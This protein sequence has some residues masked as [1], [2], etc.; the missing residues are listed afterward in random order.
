MFGEVNKC[1]TFVSTKRNNKTKNTHT[2]KTQAE[3][4]QRGQMLKINGKIY[5]VAMKPIE[6]SFSVKV[7]VASMTD[8]GKKLEVLSL[9]H[10]SEPT[11]R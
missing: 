1:L 2:M 9:I 11:R 10:I 3:L 4:L 6:T 7:G 5:K 8:E